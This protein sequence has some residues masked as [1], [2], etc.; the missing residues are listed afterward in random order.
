MPIY[1]ASMKYQEN[2]IGYV[3]ARNDYIWFIVTAAKGTNSTLNSY[4]SSYERIHRCLVMMIV[5]PLQ[6]KEGES[7]DS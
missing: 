6:F 7:A 2:G 5:L 3:L 4:R 1:D